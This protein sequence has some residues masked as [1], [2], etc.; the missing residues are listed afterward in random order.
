MTRGLF[1]CLSGLILIQSG[2]GLTDA[3]HRQVTDN[4]SRIERAEL[5]QNLAA[6][7]EAAAQLKI[8]SRKTDFH[9]GEMITLDVA[10]LNTSSRPL[11]FRK[12]S[13][14]RVNALNDTGQSLGIQQ[15]GVAD[16]AL[17]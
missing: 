15:Y 2:T 4:N 3:K 16:R 17:V 11:F 14:L 10:L 13:E 9:Q 7:F 12:L 5:R 8:A 6:K 1:F